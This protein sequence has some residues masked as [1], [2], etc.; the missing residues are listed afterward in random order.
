M[1]EISDNRTEIGF[2]WYYFEKINYDNKKNIL[3]KMADTM[4][5]TMFTK[6]IGKIPK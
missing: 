1:D 4:L 3:E 2:Y 5:E 6:L